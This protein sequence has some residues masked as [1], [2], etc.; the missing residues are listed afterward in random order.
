MTTSCPLIRSIDGF[1]RYLRA[2]LLLAWIAVGSTETRGRDGEAHAYIH[3]QHHHI[4]HALHEYSRPQ[5]R[6][7][8]A[9]VVAHAQ[10][11]YCSV[12]TGQITTAGSFPLPS[13]FPGQRAK[14][15][16]RE[17]YYCP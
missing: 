13:G 16:L 14:G 12:R 2:C 7:A 4:T 11:H 15:Q 8:L 6:P 9:D 5:H 10:A 1:S 3:H 17:N